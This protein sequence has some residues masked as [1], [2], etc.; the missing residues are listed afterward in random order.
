MRE[1]RLCGRLGVCAA[2]GGRR[3]K[4]KVLKSVAEAG[5][6]EERL[7]RQRCRDAPLS[8]VLSVVQQPHDT[9]QGKLFGA[10]RTADR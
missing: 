3:A 1:R 8:S 4:A 7:G 5:A 2:R 10:R 6:G 9:K